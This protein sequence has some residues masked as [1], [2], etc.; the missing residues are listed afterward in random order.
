MS[1]DLIPPKGAKHFLKGTWHKVGAD[2][3][4][5][6]HTGEQWISSTKTMQQYNR[7]ILRVKRELE[8]CQVY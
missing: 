3:K 6:I 5:Y 7:E 2:N 8:L 1:S 4:I